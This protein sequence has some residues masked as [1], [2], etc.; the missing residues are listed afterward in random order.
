MNE[1]NNIGEIKDELSVEDFLE[2]YKNMTLDDKILIFEDLS[3]LEICLLVAMK[4][5]SQIYDNNPFTFEM[6]ITRYNKFANSNALTNA[7]P[8][9]VVMKAFEH[10]IVSTTIVWFSFFC[11]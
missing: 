5:H 9:P 7:A 6:I 8:R 3:V 10:I 11:K 1:D 2:E 4:H